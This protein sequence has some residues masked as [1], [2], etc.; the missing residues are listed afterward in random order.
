MLIIYLIVV[1]TLIGF[2]AG[3]MSLSIAYDARDKYIRTWKRIIAKII[4]FF[5]VMLT[6]PI[7]LGIW[8][9]ATLK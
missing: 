2:I 4:V 9:G 1:Y 5:V 3:G 6:W 8:L 7:W